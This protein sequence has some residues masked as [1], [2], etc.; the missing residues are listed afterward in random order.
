MHTHLSVRSHS[1]VPSLA[2]A[3]LFFAHVRRFA[4]TRAHSVP[5]HGDHIM[6]RSSSYLW[7]IGLFVALNILSTQQSRGQEKPAPKPGDAMIEKYLAQETAKLSER[8]LDGAKTRA[9]WEASRP[10]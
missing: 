7:F 3:R 8:F 6:T 10:R 9:E 4:Y 5:V 1:L 2:P